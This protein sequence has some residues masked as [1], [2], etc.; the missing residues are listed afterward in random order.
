MFPS[1]VVCVGRCV[2]SAVSAVIYAQ[3]LLSTIPLEPVAIALLLLF[4]LLYIWGI[5]DSANV[6]F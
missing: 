2:V 3:S 6:R 5:H 4:A 1:C